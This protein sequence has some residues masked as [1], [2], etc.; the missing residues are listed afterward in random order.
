M[1]RDDTKNACEADYLGHML[2]T[3]Y[4]VAGAH[5]QGRATSVR[6]CHDVFTDQFILRTF[7]APIL[8]IF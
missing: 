8:N 4:R 3:Q 2:F 7:L 5:N 1:L 6:L